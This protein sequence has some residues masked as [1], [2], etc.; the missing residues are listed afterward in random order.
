MRKTLFVL[1]AAALLAGLTAVPASA[2]IHEI[3]GSHCSFDH[4]GNVDPPGQTPTG[5]EFD[6]SDF[7]A[8]LATGIYDENTIQIDP[9]TEPL[10]TVTIVPAD[11]DHPASKFSWDG[12]TFDGP[13][14]VDLDGDDVFDIQILVP[15]LVPDHPS[16]SNCKNLSH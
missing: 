11:I 5:F 1:I 4:R 8:L 15:A 10:P 12:E 9:T 2:T 6:Q 3:V 14:P 7:R 13:F 16:L